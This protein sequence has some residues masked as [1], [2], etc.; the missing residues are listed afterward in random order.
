MRAL[1]V[2]FVC[3]ALGGLAQAGQDAAADGKPILQLD[4]GG[5]MGAIYG[6][7]FAKGG[8]LIVSAGDDKVIR[9]WD[10]ET[11][12]IVSSLRGESGAGDSGKISALAL[13]PDGKLLAAAGEFGRAA[14][15]IYDLES[16]TLAILLLGHDKPV[17]A[18]AFS[19]DGRLLLSGGADGAVIIWDVEARRGL[20]RLEAPGAQDAGN[21][22]E[23][24]AFTA[25]HE[26]AVATGPDNTVHLW[27]ADTGRLTATLRGHSGRVRSLAVSANNVIASGDAAG[28]IRLWE[29]ATGK[30]LGEWNNQSPSDKRPA[31]V[32]GL[33]FSPDGRLLL[34]GNGGRGDNYRVHLWDLETRS[35]KLAYDGHDN[36]VYA[37]AISPDGRWAAT[38]GGNNKEIHVLDLNRGGIAQGPD[39]KPSILAAQGKPV[40][41]V[42]ISSDGSKI[43]WG[44]LKNYASSSDRGPL[45]REMLI[46]LAA[47]GK[48]GAPQQVAAGQSWQRG[49]NRD[50][51]A[52]LAAR[53]GGLPFN[54]EDEILS[55]S[56]DGVQ[57]FEIAAG[58]KEGLRHKSFTFADDGKIVVSGG[59]TGNF[60]AY[61]RDGSYLGSFAG[62]EDIV[63]ALAPSPDGRLLIS[64]GG[65]QTVRL[66]NLKTR[67]LLVTLFDGPDGEWAMWTPQGYYTGSPGADKMVGWQINRGSG[68]GRRLRHRRAVAQASEPARYRGESHPARLGG[69]SCAHVP[70]HRVQA[71]GPACPARSAPSHCFARAGQYREHAGQRRLNGSARRHARSSYAHPHPG[72]RPPAR[73]FPAGKRAEVRTR[74]A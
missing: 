25:N 58:E 51:G 17:R 72:E 45:L 69:G 46:P 62:H 42:G 13:S 36:G 60:A 43:A 70:R 5:H 18:L 14:I 15:R 68:K 64:G 63:W 26:Y 29:T 44:T 22:V 38:A 66:W 10:R 52:E 53:A 3:F 27:R 67:E 37:V 31:S 7:L 40:W 16:G 56:E 73:R 28:A 21:I 74:R 50:R 47:G 1:A 57:K 55:L 2:L 30:F 48:L 23:A 35:E 33:A 19:D 61:A 59:G 41:A 8:R 65:D 11:G 32:R 49:M 24:V 34:S 4:T 9:V 39:G 54:R 71:F 12:K 6:L 20:R